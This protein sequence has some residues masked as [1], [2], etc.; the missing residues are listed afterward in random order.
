MAEILNPVEYAAQVANLMAYQ[1]ENN[2]TDY[3]T[4][5]VFI[6]EIDF[7]N[8]YMGPNCLMSWIKI[9]E[10]EKVINNGEDL[11]K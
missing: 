3:K 6:E 7:I 5:P 4:D 11:T 1:I 10:N 2:L 8:S 9:V